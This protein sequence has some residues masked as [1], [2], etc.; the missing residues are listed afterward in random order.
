MCAM[1]T[2]DSCCT[3]SLFSTMWGSI[4]TIVVY[5]EELWGWSMEEHHPHLYTLARACY[6]RMLK[7]R[8]SINSSSNQDV[9]DLPKSFHA[10]LRGISTIL[11]FLLASPFLQMIDYNNL[12]TETYLA[13]KVPDVKRENRMMV[14][15]SQIYI[16]FQPIQ[17]NESEN[18]TRNNNILARLDELRRE[19][20]VVEITSLVTKEDVV[21]N[22]HLIIGAVP[23]KS[24]LANT[25]V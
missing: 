25:R 21:K 15:C 12:R 10:G 23:L 14:A 13:K 18:G 6:N 7:W 22:S 8:S 4:L 24:Q 3:R 5:T 19:D 17:E 16:Y 2:C 1:D 20:C 9:V 11:D